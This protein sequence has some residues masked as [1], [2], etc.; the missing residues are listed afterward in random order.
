VWTLLR[1][2]NVGMGQAT[3]YSKHKEEEKEGN[4]MLP[5]R[6]MFW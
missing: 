5:K 3:I 1:N 4:Q 6:K 2:A